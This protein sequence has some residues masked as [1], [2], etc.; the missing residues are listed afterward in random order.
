MLALSF[1]G[2]D[3]ACVKTPPD[4]MILPRFAGEFD[5]ALCRWR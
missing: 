3:P 2:F 4:D 1:S 5:D